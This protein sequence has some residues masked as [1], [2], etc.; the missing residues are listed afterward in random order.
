MSENLSLGQSQELFA[1]CIAKLILWLDSKGYKIRLVDVCPSSTRKGYILKLNAKGQ[2]ERIGD[3]VKFE[4]AVHMNP[5][6]HYFFTAGD[7][8][9]FK[10][11]VWLNKGDEPIWQEA[12][13]YW[14]S[15][16]PNCT[17]G[18]D[19]KDANHFSITYNGKK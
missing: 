17:W 1:V 11:N 15:L 14:K 19:F 7:L 10:Y 12:G 16:H 2:F 6:C 8:N 5:G 9:L 3:I 18:G 4:D 13:A